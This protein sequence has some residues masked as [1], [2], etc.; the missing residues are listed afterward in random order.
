MAT[1]ADG[2]ERRSAESASLGQRLQEAEGER[3]RL[4]EQVQHLQERCR[5]LEGNIRCAFVGPLPI[6][7]SLLRSL[8][9]RFTG[10]QG[11]ETLSVF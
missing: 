4:E 10:G 9:L 11:P 8:P 7:M 5:G 3:G 2:D 1:S 6:V